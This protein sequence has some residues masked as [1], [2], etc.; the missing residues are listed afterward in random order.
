[1]FS[2]SSSSS[3]GDRKQLLLHLAMNLR[4]LKVIVKYLLLFYLLSIF[5]LVYLAV[6]K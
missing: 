1:M 3:L 6:H 5:L 4:L 2:S